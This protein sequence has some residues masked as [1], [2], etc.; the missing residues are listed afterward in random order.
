VCVCVCVSEC[1]CMFVCVSECV[2]VF[3]VCTCVS[4]FHSSIHAFSPIKEMRGWHL[5][6]FR[7]DTRREGAVRDEVQK[8]TYWSRD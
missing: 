1:V 2:R 6:G 3:V 5:Q 8:D 7:M 4:A